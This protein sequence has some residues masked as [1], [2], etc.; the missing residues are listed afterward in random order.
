MDDS[1]NETE[2]KTF[3]MCI[4]NSVFCFSDI[5]NRCSSCFGE[6][7]E[8]N[9]CIKDTIDCTVYISEYAYKACSC[10]REEPMEKSWISTNYMDINKNELIDEYSILDEYKISRFNDFFLGYTRKTTDLVIL[11]GYDKSKKESYYICLESLNLT[12]LFI[13]THISDLLQELSLTHINSLV[14]KNINNQVFKPTYS[15][16]RFL[17]ITYRNGTVRSISLQ[18]DKEWL[19]IGNEI[20]GYTHVFR[21]L[22]YQSEPFIFDMDYT[23]DI[24]DS[25]IKIFEL[26]S[27]QFLKMEKDGYII[28][29]LD[30]DNYSYDI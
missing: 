22:E 13:P 2:D 18:I 20:L 10:K 17:S 3:E 26:K 29:R 30:D 21:M 7:Y 8:D 25:D 28:K 16:I 15:N 1:L 19:V 4:I 6:I 12:N 27:H 5:I 11:K 9:E 23:L 14:L 24:I